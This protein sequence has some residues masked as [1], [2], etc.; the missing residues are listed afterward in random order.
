MEGAYFGK[1]SNGWMTQELFYGWISKHFPIHLPPGRPVCLLVDGHSS[2]ID[3]DT[4]KFCTANQILLYCLPPHTSHVLQPLD[5]GF[6]AP[7]KQAWQD[8]V[9]QYQ[10]DEGEVISKRSFAGVFH[11]AYKNV[12]RLSSIVNAYR[13]TGIH[14]VNRHAINSKKLEPASVYSTEPSS[15][16]NEASSSSLKPGPGASKLALKALE[17]ELDDGTISLFNTR[18]EEG[19]D[20]SGDALYTAWAKLKRA[21]QP[22]ADITNK[23]SQS[24]NPAPSH[25][26]TSTRSLPSCNSGRL[27]ENVLKIPERQQAKKTTRGTARLPKH[28]SGEEMVQFLEE[29]KAQ[30]M[31][32]AK[33]KEERKAARE[34]KKKQRE[35]EKQ[36]K[37]AK[38]ASA[39]HKKQTTS[40][41]KQKAIH[42]SERTVCPVC[43]GVYEE[44][45][46]DSPIWV[47]CIWC[48]EWFHLHCTNIPPRQHARLEQVDFVCHL[49]YS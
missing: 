38:K 5:V 13:A 44:E 48:E 4:S 10:L 34:A 28:L 12:V 41:S 36:Q 26:D 22:L 33:E 43:D 7:L 16:C 24:S 27:L 6:F 14:P 23:M 45:G 8:A 47:E 19:Y 30:K 3:L 15:S 21:A 40:S 31:R 17:G 35:E 39:K 46:D 2:H 32:E 1:S 20:I 9:A 29:R 42:M 49:C 18:Y 37:A 25:A 11:S